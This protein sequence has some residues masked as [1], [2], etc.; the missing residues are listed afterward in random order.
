[1]AY[2]NV[3][4]TARLGGVQAR[5]FH[6]TLPIAVLSLAYLVDIVQL[7]F[8]DWIQSGYAPKFEKMFK[9][10]IVLTCVWLLFEQMVLSFL[11]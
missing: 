7:K 8:R 5:Y 6:H 3:Y 1:M 11:F 10:L 4:T 2:A 9:H